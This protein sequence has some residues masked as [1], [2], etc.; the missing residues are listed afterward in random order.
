MTYSTRRD[1]VSAAIQAGLG[2][3]KDLSSH[4]VS[5]G[6]WRFVL[7]HHCLATI[8]VKWHDNA[9]GFSLG[10]IRGAFTLQKIP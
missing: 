2:S 3:L 7:L 6:N 10:D 8:R 4:D 1:A 5:S 9:T